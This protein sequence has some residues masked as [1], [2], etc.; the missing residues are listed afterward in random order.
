MIK[1]QVGIEIEFLMLNAKNEIIIPPAHFDRDD[2]PLLGEIRAE[3]GK[4]RTE[5]LTNFFKAKSTIEERLP[6]GKSLLF[7]D[8]AKIPLALYRE[9]NKLAKDIDKGRALVD[10]KNLYGIDISDFSDQIVKDGKIQGVNMSC[11]LHIHFSCEEISETIVEE[12]QYEPI[13]I[14]LS[15]SMTEKNIGDGLKELATPSLSLYKHRGYT[16]K[17][18]LIARASR[19]N[20]PTIE[21]IVRSMDEKFFENFA[22]AKTNRTKYR[23]PGFY[24]LKPYGFEYRSLPANESTIQRLPEIVAYAFELLSEANKY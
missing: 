19:L 12:A 20:K 4:D 5:V 3:P 24:E 8:L 18:K 17:K 9:A 13:N 23:Q 22:P 10:V 2:F 6:Q 1:S 15:W 16:E 11:G 7:A 14:P 21:F